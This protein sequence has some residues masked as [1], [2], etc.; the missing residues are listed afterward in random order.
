MVGKLPNR[1][2]VILWMALLVSAL[3]LLGSIAG[4]HPAHTGIM[5]IASPH[6]LPDLASDGARMA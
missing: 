5:L 3:L 2:V 4:A 1:L 6:H